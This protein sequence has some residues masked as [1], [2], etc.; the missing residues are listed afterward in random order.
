MNAR[1]K[2]LLSM[3]QYRPDVSKPDIK[4]I[5]LGITFEFRGKDICLIGL[6]SRKTLTPTEIGKLDLITR[7]QL[8][9]PMEYLRS[10]LERAMKEAPSQVI[11]FFS[12][13]HT[14]ALEVTTPEKVSVPPSFA[15]LTNANELL[16]KIAELIKRHVEKKITQKPRR[17]RGKSALAKQPRYKD[18]YIQSVPACM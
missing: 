10:E 12:E 17:A 11:E 8:E 9:S 1:P 14:W 13:Q 7:G 6:L 3:I 16:G 18:V 2:C 5:P 15:K 4:S